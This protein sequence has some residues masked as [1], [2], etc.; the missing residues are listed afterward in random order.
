MSQHSTETIA[1]QLTARELAIL[2]GGLY[3]LAEHIMSVDEVLHN[4]LKE[5]LASLPSK[6]CL[7]WCCLT[8]DTPHLSET[9]LD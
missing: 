5:A 8:S 9:H 7:K 1:V 4:K 2:G 3:E 6:H